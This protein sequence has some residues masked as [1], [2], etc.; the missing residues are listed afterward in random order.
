[1]AASSGRRIISSASSGSGW[2]QD[3]THVKGVPLNRL[4][5][6]RLGPEPE[7][8]VTVLLAEGGS[9]QIF[10]SVVCAPA[11]NAPYLR[12]G[13]PWQVNTTISISCD[14]DPK[15]C[16]GHEI[17]TRTGRPVGSA[18]EAAAE[19]LAATEWLLARPRHHGR[20]E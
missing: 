3:P 5:Y 2:G 18:I 14:S 15:S 4:Y 19:V 12:P 13:P 1:M 6:Q 7:L 16:T 9:D 10:V 20:Q 17:D 11:G 8:P